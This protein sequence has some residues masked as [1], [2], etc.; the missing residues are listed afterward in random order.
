MCSEKDFINYDILVQY[1][2]RKIVHS[3]LEFVS[4][5]GLPDS[6]CFYIT[7]LTS[8]P[9]VKMPIYLKSRYPQDITIVIQYQF[10]DLKVCKDYFLI[11]L[12]FGEAIENLEIPFSALVSFTDPSVKFVLQFN[13]ILFN[14]NKQVMVNNKYVNNTVINRKKEVVTFSD[15]SNIIVLDSFRK[16]K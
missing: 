13:P 16:G 6:H 7:F 2:L 5:N 11:C 12:S 8:H 3:V 14:F 15:D 10:W 4:N 9:G 1:S